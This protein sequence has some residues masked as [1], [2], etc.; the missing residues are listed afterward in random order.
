MR[1][2]AV[3]RADFQELVAAGQVDANT[4]VFDGTVQFI[5]DLRRGGFETTFAKSWH[6]RCVQFFPTSL[7]FST[8][9]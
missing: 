1:V 3:S 8:I 7:I 6:A 9:S 4:P 2:H 5:G